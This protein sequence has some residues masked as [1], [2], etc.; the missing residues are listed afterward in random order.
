MDQMAKAF[1]AQ[2]IS[3]DINFGNCRFANEGWSVSCGR[4]KLSRLIIGDLYQDIMAAKSQKYWIDKG[5]ITTATSKQIDW[6]L[7]D[8]AMKKVPI[9]W[10]Q[11]VSKH[12]CGFC[13]VGKG[14]QQQG[15]QGYDHCP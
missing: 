1:M 7:I 14:L 2:A 8:T 15:K 10:R 9:S 11:W 3:H 5:Q 13:A 4:E 6:S 12:S